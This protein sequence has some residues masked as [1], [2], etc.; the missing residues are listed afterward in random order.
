MPSRSRA[1]DPANALL[2]A[3]DFAIANTSASESHDFVARHIPL[4]FAEAPPIR[5]AA[6]LIAAMVAGNLI[7][8]LFGFRTFQRRQ[9]LY[10]LV[11]ATA[12]ADLGRL[13]DEDWD[14]QV[15]QRGQGFR[16]HHS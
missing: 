4:R 1:L 8:I 3:L 16:F 13:T 12:N 6:A 9:V 11:A 5:I 10:L 7:A 2:N 14:D 15:F